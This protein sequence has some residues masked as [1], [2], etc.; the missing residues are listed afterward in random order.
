[1][2]HVE[3][4]LLLHCP[5]RVP[6]HRSAPVVALLRRQPQRHLCA[7]FDRPVRAMAVRHIVDRLLGPP[8]YLFI[9]LSFL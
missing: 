7:G 1:M 6:D 2:I 9:Y 3:L 8:G 5:L 4:A